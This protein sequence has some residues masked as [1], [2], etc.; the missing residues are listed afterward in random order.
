M[1]I[2]NKVTKMH[3]ICGARRGNMC[4]IVRKARFRR[5]APEARQGGPGTNSNAVVSQPPLHPPCPPWLAAL[6]EQFYKNYV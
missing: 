4:D 3:R 6:W 2:V 5:F 1:Q